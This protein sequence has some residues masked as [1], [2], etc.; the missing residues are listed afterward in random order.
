MI[1]HNFFDFLSIYESFETWFQMLEIS[2]GKDQS[3]NSRPRPQRVRKSMP[4]ALRTLQ[5]RH[6]SIA[7]KEI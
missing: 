7:P 1:S 6:H 5:L 4:R 3:R 2:K